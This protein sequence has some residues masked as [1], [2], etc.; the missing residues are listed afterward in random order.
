MEARFSRY[1]TYIRPIVKNKQVQSYS[2]ITFS[3]ITSII[4]AIFAIQ[5]TVKTIISLQK[6]INE[7]KQIL[8]QIEKKT[9][10]LSQGKQNY[11]SLDPLTKNTLLSLVPNFP[12]LPEFIDDLSSLASQNQASISGLQFQPLA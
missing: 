8:H 12:E 9:S 4:F 3:M 7:E 6:S 2:F 1:Y 5:P 11:Q 10:D